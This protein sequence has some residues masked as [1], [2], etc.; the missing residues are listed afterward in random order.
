MRPQEG[1]RVSGQDT[2]HYLRKMRQMLIITLQTANGTDRQCRAWAGMWSHRN[3]H[4]LLVGRQHGALEAVGQFLIDL[5][6][7]LPYE[8][9]SSAPPDIYQR[10]MKTY[11]ATKIHAQ[12]SID[13]LFIGAPNKQPT[14]SSA[15]K[16]VH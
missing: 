1:S 8:S 5:N 13:A 7:H 3:A 4:S 11:V 14:C 15:G 12:M 2:H 9:S 6:R 16:W 10:G